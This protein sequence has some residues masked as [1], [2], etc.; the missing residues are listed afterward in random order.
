VTA[1]A[2]PFILIFMVVNVVV[3]VGDGTSWFHG[4][5]DFLLFYGSA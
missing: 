1:A 5:V 2:I 4:F 3:D